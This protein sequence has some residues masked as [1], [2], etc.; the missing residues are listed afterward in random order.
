MAKNTKI[1]YSSTQLAK[2]LATSTVTQARINLFDPS[3]FTNNTHL[4]KEGDTVTLKKRVTETPWGSCEIIG[5]R[6]TQAHKSVLESI[7]SVH[8][9]LFKHENEDITLLVRVPEVLEYMNKKNH[10]DVFYGLLKDMCLTQI[11]VVT[12]KVNIE[13]HI[14]QGFRWSNVPDPKV[15]VSAN[16]VNKGW[17]PN[18]FAI[19]IGAAFLKIYE[20]D[21]NINYPGLVAEINRLRYG[22]SMAAVRFLL[23]Q[24]KDTQYVTDCDKLMSYIGAINQNTSR[25]TKS[26][27][28][29]KFKSEAEKLAFFGITF[30]D[31][32]ILFNKPD[33][34]YF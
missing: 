5:T 13:G 6:L 12:K 16:N 19:T 31:N 2:D 11:K 28:L 3:Y 33:A 25:Q 14:I 23:T 17:N 10:H 15:R 24:S 1:K 29:A 21:L 20:Q 7:I 18:Y 30:D 4:L 32:R 34:V 22:E 26:K 27:I 8:H 9:G